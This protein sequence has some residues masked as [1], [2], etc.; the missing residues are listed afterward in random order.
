MQLIKLYGNLNLLLLFF[1]WCCLLSSAYSSYS[2][3]LVCLIF[4][5]L[6]LLSTMCSTHSLRDGCVYGKVMSKL[7]YMQKERMCVCVNSLYVDNFYFTPCLTMHLNTQFAYQ[8]ETTIIAYSHHQCT[9]YICIT[10]Y[11]GVI[12]YYFYWGKRKPT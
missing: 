1:Y 10:C 12:S 2:V 8:K 6:S 3:I 5:P 9:A 11:S 7:L 4:F